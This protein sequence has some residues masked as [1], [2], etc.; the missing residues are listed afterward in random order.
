MS[1]P[2]NFVLSQL[3]AGLRDELHAL[4]AMTWLECDRQGFGESRIERAL[5]SSALSEVFDLA[6]ESIGP[7]ET[8]RFVSDVCNE[9]LKSNQQ[10]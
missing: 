7:E 1:E 4:L 8:A 10:R 5:L 3:C 2:T 6:V 9:R